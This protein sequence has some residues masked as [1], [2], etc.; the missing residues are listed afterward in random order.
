M[1]KENRIATAT[2]LF[3]HVN[4][5]C[6]KPLSTITSSG[7]APKLPVS[8]SHWSA[9]VKQR[10]LMVLFDVYEAKTRRFAGPSVI[11]A[12]CKSKQQWHLRVWDP[13]PASI[14]W[15]PHC[16]WKA[17][18]TS[19]CGIHSVCWELTSLSACQLKVP[20][21]VNKHMWEDVM[22]LLDRSELQMG[23]LHIHSETS[24]SAACWFWGQT[25]WIRMEYSNL[26]NPE[27]IHRAMVHCSDSWAQEMMVLVLHCSYRAED[28][29]AR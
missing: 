10:P 12:I 3:T 21:K 14:Q 13:T 18:K 26:F 6:S 2:E 22:Y 17:S 4:T 7:E 20:S 19:L 27:K 25:R 9:K 28:T 16:L 11:V 23:F 24:G 15:Q 5:S 8:G 1:E 29:I